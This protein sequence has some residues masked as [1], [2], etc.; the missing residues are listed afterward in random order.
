MIKEYIKVT[1]EALSQKAC[2]PYHKLLRK[3]LLEL[4][5]LLKE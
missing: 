4:E 1:K 2:K 3:K 5:R